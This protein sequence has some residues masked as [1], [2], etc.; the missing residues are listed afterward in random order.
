MRRNIKA[1]P[2][3][4][5]KPMKTCALLMSTVLAAAAFADARPLMVGAPDGE[6]NISITIGGTGTGDQA[7]IAAWANGDKGD[8]PLDW[9]EYAD[10]GTVAAADTSKTFQIPAEWRAKSGAVRFF[11]M[12]GPKPYAKRFDYVTRPVVSTDN[13][14]WINTTIYPDSTLDIC[15]KVRSDYMSGEP[16][17]CPFGFTRSNSAA[18]YIFP[19][20]TTAYWFDFFGAKATTSAVMSRANTA[21]FTSVSKLPAAMPLLSHSLWR[22]K[23]AIEFI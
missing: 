13:D 16:S 6:G 23:G 11:L 9:T 5:G 15:V 2:L 1:V 7:L 4:K 17:M 14:T 21:V 19:A 10:A 3:K 20:S 18:V 22:S 8:D 12:S